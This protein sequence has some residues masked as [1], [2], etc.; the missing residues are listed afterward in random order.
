MGMAVIPGSPWRFPSRRGWVRVALLVAAALALGAVV[1]WTSLRTLSP[2]E[3]MDAFIATR[4]NDVDDLQFI[5]FHTAPPT[6]E[7]PS[8]RLTAA[9]SSEAAYDVHLH[10]ERSGAAAEFRDNIEGF[11]RWPEVQAANTYGPVEKCFSARGTFYCFGIDGTRAMRSYVPMDV[12]DGSV[13][14]LLLL[15]TA[16]KHYYGTN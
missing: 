9:Y 6:R 10:P 16:R 13:K 4:S 11:D 2:A 7:S 8:A 1:L 12:D 14:A 15:R 5:R 3:Q